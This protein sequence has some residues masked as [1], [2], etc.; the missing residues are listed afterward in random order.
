MLSEFDGM[1]N[2]IHRYVDGVLDLSGRIRIESMMR[3]DPALRE[4]VE[5]YRRQQEGLRALFAATTEIAP[6]AAP[7][8]ERRARPFVRAPRLHE[9]ALAASL[10]LLGAAGGW[11][12]AIMTAAREPQTRYA[13][14]VGEVAAEGFRAHRVFVVDR[15]H[16]VEVGE[17]EEAHL[18]A[19]LSNRMERTIHAPDFSAHGLHLVGGRLLPSQTGPSAQ[20]M[21]EDAG[22]RRVTIYMR[23][24]AQDIED[25]FLATEDD[26]RAFLWARHGLSV[27]VIGEIDEG[28]LLAL[29]KLS[30]YS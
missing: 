1:E 24:E 16:P 28:Q 2:D 10:L 25:G 20:F 12:G 18:L 17:D 21:Y 14:V 22:G 30:G 3:G 5:A 8:R 13:E 6:D 19:W 7:L 15:R 26:L 29:S 4:K 11:S 9:A 23:A 27:S